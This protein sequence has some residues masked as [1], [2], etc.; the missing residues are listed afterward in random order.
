M[1]GSTS[2]M[3]EF[4]DDRELT[5]HTKSSLQKLDE[6]AEFPFLATDGSGEQK[7]EAGI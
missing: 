1:F 5:R 4:F 6:S 2:S 7:E 3:K